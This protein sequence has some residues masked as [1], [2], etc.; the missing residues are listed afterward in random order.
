MTPADAVPDIAFA[1]TAYAAIA[2]AYSVLAWRMFRWAGRHG[3]L[4]LWP[5]VAIIFG[6][7]AS[8]HLVHRWEGFG[9]PQSQSARTRL[10]LAFTV[11]GIPTFGLASL[12]VWRRAARLP[13]PWP[14]PV[15]LLAAVGAFFVG[16]GTLLLAPLVMDMRHL[17]SP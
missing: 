4:I 6:A 3:L 12:S 5:V 15:D 16:F 10:F 14:R 7:W 1:A 9:H 17:L 13:N 8:Y 11:A 2:A